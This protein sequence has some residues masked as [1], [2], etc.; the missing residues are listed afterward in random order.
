MN[1]ITLSVVSLTLITLT[2]TVAFAQDIKPRLI[3]FGYLQAEET[4]QGRA[5][6]YLAQQVEKLSGGKMKL[7]P[8]GGGVLGSYIQ[9]QKNLIDGKQEMMVSSTTA[10]AGVS[11]EMGLWDTPFLFTN[12]QEADAILDGPVGQKVMSKLP[13]KGLVGLVYW[14]NGF[15]NTTNSK[16]SIDTMEDF[17]GM[18]LRVMPN[19]TY[20]ETFKLLGA[21]PLP[22][23]FTKL[24]SA[25]KDG[26]VEGQENPYTLILSNKFHEVQKY[27]TAT[28][29]VYSPWIVLV[30]KKYWDSLSKDEQKVLLDAAK[31]S[32]DFERKDT[33][34]ISRKALAELRENG[35]QF[36]KLAPKETG[37]LRDKLT[38]VNA[39]IAASVGVDLW[40]EA[41]AELAKLRK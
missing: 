30:N 15:R 25:L 7:Q 8:I 10:L 36:S 18:K 23:E 22:L 16:K 21:S 19:P 17:T 32:R 20:V 24:Y 37:R 39:S 3:Q 4:N 1:R 40:N 34:E 6:N 27:I 35:M 29:H 14:E 26:T 2:G 28:N 5:A 12:T 31:A 41:Q 33:R 9:Q 13:E 11:K 38:R